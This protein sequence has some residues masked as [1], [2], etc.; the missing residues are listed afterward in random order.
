MYYFVNKPQPLA[1][2]KTR[3]LVTDLLKKPNPSLVVYLTSAM[4]QSFFTS[5]T[6]FMLN[7]IFSSIKTFFQKHACFFMHVALYSV[8]TAVCFY[9]CGISV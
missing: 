6:Q 4:V 7:C 1:N 2:S 8:P 3:I 9:A 5:L